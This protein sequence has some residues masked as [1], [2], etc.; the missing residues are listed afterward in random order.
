[1]KIMIAGSSGGIGVFLTKKFDLDTNELYLTY[2]TSKD[3]ITIDIS[4]Q[5]K[6]IYS[7]NLIQGKKV[8]TEKI[9]KQ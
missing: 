9:V 5:P 6:G 4:S 8:F 1:M 3:K 7:V 2:N